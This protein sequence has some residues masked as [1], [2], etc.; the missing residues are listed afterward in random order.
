MVAK[1]AII[2]FQENGAGFE[3]AFFEMPVLFRVLNFFKH[4]IFFSLE[5]GNNQFP[6]KW[7][8]V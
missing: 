1:L 3:I 2:S 8:R 4:S 6:R 5:S 7:S